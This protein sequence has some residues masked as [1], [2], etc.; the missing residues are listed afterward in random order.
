M[1][2]DILSERLRLVAITPPLMHM[3]SSVLRSLLN[4]DVPSA[5]PPEH[6][7]P[8]VFDFMQRQ[9]VQTPWAAGWNRYVLLRAKRPILIGTLGGFPRTESEAEIGYSML[10]SWQCRGLATEGT[11]TLIQEI[12]RNQRFETLTAQTL[13]GLIPSIRVLE[14]CGFHLVGPGDDEGTI[15]YRVSRAELPALIPQVEPCAPAQSES[16]EHDSRRDFEN[17]NE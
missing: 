16:R 13:P 14:K 5:W 2:P 17:R 1:L 12:L 10:G 15:R 7:E 6:W 4:A 9:Y 8:H 3:D 11:R